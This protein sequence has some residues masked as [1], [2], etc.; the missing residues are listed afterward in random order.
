MTLRS[1]FLATSTAAG[2]ILA[3]SSLAF[4]QTRTTT[5]IKIGSFP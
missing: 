1:R 5:A 2:L 3:T 4:A